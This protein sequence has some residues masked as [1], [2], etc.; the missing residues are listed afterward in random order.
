SFLHVAIKRSNRVGAGKW[1]ELRALIERIAHAQVLHALDELA[2]ELVGYFLRLNKAFGRDARLTVVL[3]P[4][5]D[6]SGD[7]RLQIGAGHHD[8]RVAAAQFQHDFLDSFGCGN[9][10]LN[11]RLLTAR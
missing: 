8:E 4:R 5:V 1:T 2:L 3:N 9:S 10:N 7:S 6:C 11:P